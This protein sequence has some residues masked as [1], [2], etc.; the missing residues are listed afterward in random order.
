MIDDC[1]DWMS[2]HDAVAYVEATQQCYENLAIELL[3]QA[4]HGLKIRTRT[5]QSSPRWV[6]SGSRYY[7]DDGIDLEFCREDVLKLWPK[8]QK[9]APRSRPPESR[10]AIWN[11]I[12]T[13]IH[14]LWPNG[15]TV[16]AKDRNIRIHEWL[17]SHEI[18]RQH[19]D[20]TRTIQ[21]VLR[22]A[23]EARK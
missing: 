2:F 9:D 17:K 6:V 15:I 21:R 13:A 3:R 1:S 16:K 23:R 18:I 7:P 10:S 22:A 19:N 5:V 14:E 4:A 20:V 8:R 11:G 12:R